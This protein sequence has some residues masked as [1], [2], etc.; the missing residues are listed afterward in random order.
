MAVISR[1]K[2]RKNL[3]YLLM[4]FQLIVGLLTVVG[5]GLA[6]LEFSKVLMKQGS[7][8]RQHSPF[9]DSRNGANIWILLFLDM[10]GMFMA[11][12]TS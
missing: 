11:K 4:F 2:S 9:A 3:P 12:K 8:S 7:D 5:P 6:S 1:G 10:A